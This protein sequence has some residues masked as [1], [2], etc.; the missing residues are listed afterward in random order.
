[1]SDLLYYGGG[2]IGLFILLCIIACFF[3]DLF[4]SIFCSLL[5]IAGIVLSIILSSKNYFATEIIELYNGGEWAWICSAALYILMALRYLPCV[6]TQTEKNTYLIF[7]TLI[8]N[9]ESHILGIGVLLGSPLLFT[10][11]YFFL[12]FFLIEFMGIYSSIYAIFIILL[13]HS[14]IGLIRAI[15]NSY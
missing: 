8:E 14:I 1:M 3:K 11:P 7:G 6:S 5:S 9:T 15:R 12:V 10:I 2:L 4:N 13:L